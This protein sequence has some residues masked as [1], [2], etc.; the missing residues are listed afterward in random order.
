MAGQVPPSGGGAE[1]LEAVAGESGFVGGGILLQQSLV[2]AARR[3]DVLPVL[4]EAPHLVER[5]RGF[6]RLGKA[7]DDL[8]IV[9]DRRVGRGEVERLAYRVE[10]VRHQRMARIGGEKLLEAAPGGG[11]TPAVELLPGALVHLVR[12]GDGAR[13][14]SRGRR[15]ARVGRCGGPDGG[16][17]LLPA[18]GAVAPLPREPLLAL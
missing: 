12:A 18:G 14:R 5:G 6:G 4:L 7:R 15:A 1:V 10:R 16:G 2:I 3:G 13:R 17:G 11:E 8:G 9:G